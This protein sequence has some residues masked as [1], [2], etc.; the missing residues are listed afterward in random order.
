[1]NSEKP[2]KIDPITIACWN[3]S[4]DLVVKGTVKVNQSSAN[5]YCEI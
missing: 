1:M 5:L 3:I 4:Y 2:C